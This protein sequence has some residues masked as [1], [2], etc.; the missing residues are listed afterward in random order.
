MYRQLSFLDRRVTL[1]FQV[2]RV[3]LCGE[4]TSNRLVFSRITV[5]LKLLPQRLLHMTILTA[6]LGRSRCRLANSTMRAGTKCTTRVP[7]R[8]NQNKS[9][10]KYRPHSTN[11]RHHICKCRAEE[12]ISSESIAR[13]SRHFGGVVGVVCYHARAGSWLESFFRL[14]TLASRRR[15]AGEVF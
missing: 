11:L 4:T 13:A 15:G 8:E 6:L 9:P 1:P 2:F 12:E 3:H 5:E 10:K 7:A 14:A